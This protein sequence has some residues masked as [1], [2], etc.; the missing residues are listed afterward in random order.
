MTH[1]DIGHVDNLDKTQIETL[2]TCWITLLERISKESSISIDEIVGS[3][4]GD[5]LFRSV[6]YDNPDVLI[7][8]WLRARKWDVNAAVQQLIDTLNWRYE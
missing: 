3:S 4:Q 1:N 5:V 8:R 6:G 2:K 7:L